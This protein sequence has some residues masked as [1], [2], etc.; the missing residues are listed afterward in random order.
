[1]SII[2]LKLTSGEELMGK[3]V[4]RDMVSITLED[5]KVVVPAT[6][7]D[8]SLSIRTFPWILTS[9]QAKQ[10]INKGF[11]VAEVPTDEKI[12]KQYIQETSGILL[13]K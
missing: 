7:P 3:F 2:T 11:I 10:A 8:G 1:M 5:I 4:E 6:D 13:F 9:M 12:A